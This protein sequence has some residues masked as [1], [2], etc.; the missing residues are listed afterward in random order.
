MC[1]LCHHLHNSSYKLYPLIWSSNISFKNILYS[2]FVRHMM[3]Q[4][5]SSV[6]WWCHELLSLLDWSVT[7]LPELKATN[8]LRKWTVLT[9]RGH[10]KSYNI[11]LVHRKPWVITLFINTIILFQAIDTM[12][13]QVS[14]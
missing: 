12:G 13:N 1:H 14:P 9:E 10:P 3:L 5:C 6:D 8:K 7:P 11:H 2:K 4:R